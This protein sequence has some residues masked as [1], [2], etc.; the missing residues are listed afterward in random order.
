MAVSMSTSS[1]R[2]LAALALL[3][4]VAACSHRDTSAP[5]SPTAGPPRTLYRLVPP[6]AGPPKVIAE[7]MRQVPTGPAASP[8]VASPGTYWPE[9]ACVQFHTD[10]HFM[11]WRWCV[12]SVSLRAGDGEM[13]LRCVWE[14]D[15]SFADATVEKGSDEG[16][17]N[18]YVVDGRGRRYDTVATTEFVRTGG[19]L[20]KEAPAKRGDFVFRVSGSVYSPL[21]FHDDDQKTAIAGI[22]LDAAQ[23]SAETRRPRPG[24]EDVRTLLGRMRTADQ[25]ELVESWGGLTRGADTEPSEKHHI[26]RREGGRSKQGVPVLSATL[27]GFLALLAEAPVVEGP[28]R[29]RLD[30]TD[31]YPHFSITIGTGGDPIVFFSDSQGADRVPWAVQIEGVRYV[32]PSDAPARA[33][34]LVRAH[35]SPARTAVES[36]DVNAPS[37]GGTPLIEAAMRR[38]VETVRALLSAGA[39]PFGVDSFDQDA[40][41]AAVNAGADDILSLLLDAGRRAHAGRSAYRRAMVAA[42]ASGRA[43]PLRL[44]LAAGADPERGDDKTGESPLHFAAA[45]GQ[46]EIVLLLIQA[47]ARPDTPDHRGFPPLVEAAR[48]GHEDVVRALLKHGAR[49]GLDDALEAAAMA[50]T[51]ESRLPTAE[52]VAAVKEVVRMLLAAGADPQAKRWDGRTLIGMLE[53]L[54]QARGREMLAVLREDA[55]R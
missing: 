23:S 43:T 25:V 12:E 44:F 24:G 52:P 35:L 20:T 11:R 29:P 22:V 27:D 30:H 16:N 17:R 55:P 39:D 9:R 47:G 19:Q 34:G 6:P 1:P 40:L 36:G 42:A 33:L 41:S 32:V 3:Y 46:T 14:L 31:D 5:P 7:P 28:Y 49:S 54:P 10:D 13:T 2:I 48:N 51:W 50:G 21:T 53:S 26:L 15:D 45:G 38:Q 4:G 8:R 37:A 18:M